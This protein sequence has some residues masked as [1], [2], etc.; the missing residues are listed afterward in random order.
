MRRNNP[1]ITNKNKA[2]IIFLAAVLAA[3]ACLFAPAAAAPARDVSNFADVSP[4]DW[5][6]VYVKRLYENGTINGV[7]PNSYAPYA[8]V[9]ASEAAALIVRYLGAE[10]SAEKSRAFLM[11]N[12]TEGA[13]LWY[14][15]YIQTMCG[16][17]IFDN[18]DIERYGLI[19]SAHG[20]VHI[21]PGAAAAINAPIKR[22]EMAKYI[23]RSFEIEKNRQKA[24]GP[25]P[26]EISGNGH[27]LITGGG[28]EEAALEKVKPL[29]SDFDD[30]PEE[31][32]IYFLKCWYNGI[33]RGNEKG[34][35]LPH[36]N[37]RRS[38]LARIIAS[39][40]YF[41]LRGVD[42]RGV[43]DI[44]AVTF[45][46]WS[47][48][49]VGGGLVLKKEKAAQILKEQA[50]YTTASDAGD[51]VNITVGQHNIIPSGFL[52]EAYVYRYDTNGTINEIGR[53]NCAANADAYFPKSNG[54]FIL[55]SGARGD[56][57]GYVY[58]VLRDL[59]R[60][61]EVAGALMYNITPA[62]VLREAPVYNLP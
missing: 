23:A 41:D 17:G 37:M 30:I 51:R 27:E 19:V 44:C 11:N 5:F 47:V 2:H 56:F 25:L 54:F 15:G 45:G 59:Q 34:E 42:I 36:N 50:K 1:V 52:F 10:Y 55:K 62:G 38:E 9:R 26:R 4:G 20:N 6:Y 29:I 14:S 33:I 31:Y 35:A 13:E 43:P 22:M 61:G 18:S 28:Y 3:Q 7:S 49:S 24:D 8:E 32:R 58:F 21:P 39:V 57:A 46:D 60:N 12:K 40:M 48:P 16:M 53:V